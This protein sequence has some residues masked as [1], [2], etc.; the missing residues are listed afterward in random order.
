MF[1]PVGDA[2]RAAAG[3]ADAARRR[4]RTPATLRHRPAPPTPDLG[5][6]TVLLH[7]RRFRPGPVHALTDTMIVASLDPVAGAVSMVS[8]PRDLGRR[9]AAR[10]PDL[11]AEDQHPR[12]RTPTTTR[13]S[14]P[15]RHRARPSS[16][17]RSASCW[18]SASTAGRRSTCPASSTVID[19]IGGVDVTFTTPSAMP[20]PRVRVRRLRDQHRQLPPRRLAR[21][22]LRPH[23]Q[24]GRRERLHPRGP[25]GRDRRRRPRPRHRRAAS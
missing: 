6:F 15:A 5:R 25:T 8:V 17:R 4:L 1:A 3:D 18:T 9:A 2:I 10:R 12:R 16:P 19:S 22:R 13:A 7:R 23:P 14:S 11:P 20:L 21:A 24:V